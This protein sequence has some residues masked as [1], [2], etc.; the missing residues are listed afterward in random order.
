M[1]CR[2]ARN[3]AVNVAAGLAQVSTGAAVDLLGFERL[4]E[5][6]GFGVVK[7]IARPAHADIA[8]GQSLAIV[9]GGVL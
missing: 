1:R 4:R 8:V 9:Y 5:A 7:R 6:F 2:A 3:E